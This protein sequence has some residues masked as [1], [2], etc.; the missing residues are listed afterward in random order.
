MFA[1][2]YFFL[3][4]SIGSFVQVV[5]TRM[6]VAP[7]AKARSKCR[8]CGEALRAYDIIPILSYL[9]LR[10][11]CR[12]CKVNFGV[13]ALVIEIIYGLVFVA[14]SHFILLGQATLW[15]ATGWLIY[16]TL[17]FIVLGIIALYD[18]LHTYIPVLYLM[19]YCV[20]TFVMLALRY[21]Y[22]PTSLV[23]IAP[24]I[25]AA[26][27]L[28]IW[29]LSKGKALGFGDVLLFAGVGAFFGIAQG[30][31]VLLLSIWSGAI[32]GS[33]MYLIQRKKGNVNANVIPFVP[34]IVFAFLIVLFTDI[35]VFSVASLFA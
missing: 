31:A 27:F 15:A 11:K 26:P 8:S 30:L 18:R 34:F 17:L 32:V 29:V 25:V 28:V 6:H 24:L 3:G 33:I 22:E 16:Y 10:G 12:Y 35:D 20:L 1:I 2:L 14:L 19:F 7:S 23:L 21:M 9:Y 4:A 13:S 5:V